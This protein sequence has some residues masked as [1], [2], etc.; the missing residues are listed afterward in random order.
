MTALSLSNALPQ[1]EAACGYQPDDNGRYCVTFATS[2]NVNM[3]NACLFVPVLCPGL[4]PE[5]LIEVM[6]RELALECDYI[7]EANCARRFQ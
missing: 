6:S 5:H 1:G 3:L 7:R 4:F 2:A